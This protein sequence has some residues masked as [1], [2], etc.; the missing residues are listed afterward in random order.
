MPNAFSRFAR[1]AI[2]T[3]LAVLGTGAA[4]SADVVATFTGSS[5]AQTL[6]TTADKGGGPVTY[7]GVPVGPF[8]F[9]AS[10]TGGT[11]L[12]TNF[13]S[14]CADYFQFVT[15]GNGYTFST[16]SASALPDV[17]GD[18]LKNAR[19]QNL[20]DKFYETATD[21]EK[22]GAFQLALWELLYDGSGSSLSIGSG[23]FSASGSGTAL[24]VAQGWLDNIDTPAPAQK[25]QLIGLL[26]PTAQDQLAAVPNTPSPV[27]APAG[28]ILLV[29]GAA[30]LY[31]RRRFTA[32][33][34]DAQA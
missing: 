7:N 25:Y 27:P 34:A 29:I 4:A 28:A 31:A 12:D 10:D 16:V 11:G 8:N 15:A 33:P 2:L 20:F 5:P 6:T 23:N 26:S 19:I 18:L 17:G 1:R 3:S 21:A 13:R 24:G 9:T 22:G 32:K 14:F 30:A